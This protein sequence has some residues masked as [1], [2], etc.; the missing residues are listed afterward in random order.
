MLS[1]TKKQKLLILL[2]FQKLNNL[3]VA[4]KDIFDYY[5]ELEIKN[6]RRSTWVIIATTDICV[7][8]AT[9]A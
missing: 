1:K 8:D 6:T 2:Q 5:C 7:L 3:T 9:G 4:S